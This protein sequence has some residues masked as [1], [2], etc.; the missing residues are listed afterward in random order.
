MDVY[1][2]DIAET[3]LEELTT[4]LLSKWSYKVKKDFL[5]K[6]NKKIEQIALQPESCPFSKESGGVYKCVVTKQNTFYY[7]IR[8]ELNE[9]EI[10][11]FFDTRQDPRK[12]RKQLK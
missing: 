11:T 10:I 4:Y 8:F 12:L 2:S 9:I 3:K 6:L 5:L 7:R 1:F